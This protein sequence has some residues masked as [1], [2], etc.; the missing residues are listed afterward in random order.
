[1]IGYS[2]FYRKRIKHLCLPVNES[3][4]TDDAI[5]MFLLNTKRHPESAN[6]WD[7]LGEALF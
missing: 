6:V 7:S 5:E 2:T 4:K 1:M 3:G